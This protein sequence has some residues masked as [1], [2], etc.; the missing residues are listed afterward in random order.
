MP[1]GPFGPYNDPGILVTGGDDS[2]ARNESVTVGTTS[3]I[4]AQYR[5][6]KDRKAII[7]RNNSTSSTAVITVNLGNSATASTG[8]VLRQY[9]SISDS[10]ET[11]YT[12]FQGTIAAIC[13]EAGGTLVI[14]E[15]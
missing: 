14:M 9:E 3:T 12:C 10:N 13:S 1:L 15:R 8:I 6:T 11:G 2:V 5:S 4:V 7:L